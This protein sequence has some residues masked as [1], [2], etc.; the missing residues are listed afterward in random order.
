MRYLFLFILAI[1]HAHAHAHAHAATPTTIHPVELPDNQGTFWLENQQSTYTLHIQSIHA[2]A[3]SIDLG[4]IYFCQAPEP[5]EE[6]LDDCAGDG[7]FP[8]SHNGTP[9][10][11][12]LAH[13]GAHSRRLQIFSPDQM[14]PHL[15]ITGDYYIKLDVHP[16]YIVACYDR[17]AATPHQQ[18]T[19]FP[20]D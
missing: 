9:Y 8:F 4:P 17:L 15:E 2:P 5:P 3:I 16:D 14:S 18:K 11:A 1:A 12:I 13:W 10:I 20:S 6:D 19:R 7:L